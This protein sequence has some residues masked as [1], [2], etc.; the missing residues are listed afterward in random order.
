[1]FLYE[2]REDSELLVKYVKKHARGVVLDMGTGSGI[3]AAA[4]AGKRSVSRVVAVDVNPDAVS[5]CR[6]TIKNKKITFL[7]SDL[8]SSLRTKKLWF[9]TIVFN[10]PYLPLEQGE[11][12]EIARALAG[13]KHGYEVVERFLA[14]ATNFLNVKC[15]ILLIFSSLT[16]KEKVDE[17]LTRHGFVW[18]LLEELP[19]FFERLYCYKITIHPSLDVALRK[20]V[21]GITYLAH[22][23]RGVVFRGSFGAKKHANVAIKIKKKESAAIGRLSNEVRWLRVLNKLDI[24]PR[25]LFSG[26]DFLVYEFVEGDFIVDFIEKN[27]HEKIK[28]ALCHVFDQ[29]FQLDQLGASKEEMHHPLK[30]IIVHRGRPVL[31]DFERMHRTR[32]PQNVTQFVQFV[33]A[34]KEVLERKG[35]FIDVGLLRSCAGLY[36]KRRTRDGLKKLLLCLL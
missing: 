26:K 27:P 34:L 2:P 18:D 10:P 19:L 12:N 31:I 9:D 21:C 33:C 28:N 16:H 13:G 32:K 17:I 8:F 7:V 5:Y 14:D 36:K 25:L 11:D 35:F 30:H 22:G 29:C 4:A 24:G 23:K 6:K 3:Q 1:M 15:Q 20:G